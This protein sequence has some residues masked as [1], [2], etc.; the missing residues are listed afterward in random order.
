[1]VHDLLMYFT[2]ALL[3]WAIVSPTVPTGAVGTVGLG[4]IACGIF[5]AIDD[6]A[7]QHD[8]MS[9]MCLGLLVAGSMVVY[10]AWRGRGRM[11]RLTD[12]RPD[13]QHT[14]PQDRRGGGAQC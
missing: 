3:L 9:L 8:A 11:R 14:Q 6:P 13:W 7:R 2:L 4:I 10:R 5:I 12:W 1:M